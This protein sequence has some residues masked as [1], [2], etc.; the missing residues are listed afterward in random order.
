LHKVV[1]HFIHIKMPERHKRE[2]FAVGA[3]KRAVFCVKI[4]VD[5]DRKAA[6]TP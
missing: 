2:D 1:A 4:E 5:P 6:G 3:V